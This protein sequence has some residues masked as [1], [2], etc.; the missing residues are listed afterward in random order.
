MR[1]CCGLIF[2]LVSETM[3]SPTLSCPGC[4]PA[5]DTLL[6]SPV[7]PD[8]IYLNVECT[9][10]QQNDSLQ[11]CANC[12]S[13]KPNVLYCIFENIW[14]QNPQTLPLLYCFNDE[15]GTVDALFR[16]LKCPSAAFFFQAYMIKVLLTLAGAGTMG[17]CMQIEIWLVWFNWK[18]VCFSIF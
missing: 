16:D 3:L 9:V 10:L 15:K 6:L 18:C 8:A 14:I 7:A 13:I 5:T 12:H 1:Q 4:W 17:Y 2:L 11:S